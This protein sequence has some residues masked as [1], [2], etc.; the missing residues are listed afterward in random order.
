M[1][2]WCL[3]LDSLQVRGGKSKS[4]PDKAVINCQFSMATFS[5]GE[6]KRRPRGDRKSVEMTW[7]LKQTL[8]AS[9]QTH[10]Y[11]RSQIDVFIEVGC[12]SE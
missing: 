3:N 9:V 5:T 2:H 8:E 1:S 6:R 12:E 7:H 4:D 11:P 10:L